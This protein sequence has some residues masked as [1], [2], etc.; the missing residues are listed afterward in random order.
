MPS[1]TFMKY[2]INQQSIPD[3]L[4]LSVGPLKLWQILAAIVLIAVA[5][6]I[7]WVGII[8]LRRVSKASD[9]TKDY[10]G[11][12]LRR[13]ELPISGLVLAG[14]LALGLPLLQLPSGIQ[15]TGTVITRA[16]AMLSFLWLGLRVVDA[17]GQVMAARAKATESKLDD[18]LVP[19][20]AKTSK[21]VLCV[22]GFVFVLQNLEVNVGSLIAGLGLGGL[23]FALAAKDTLANFFG[24]LM[25][26]VDKPFQIG[27]WVVINDVEGK[28]EEVGFR[29]SRLRTA[30]SSL[31]TVP[32]SLVTNAMI[33]NFGVRQYFTYETTLGLCYDTPAEKIE[34][35]CD[36]VREILLSD[37]RFSHRYFIVEFKEFSA[38]SLDIIISCH[39]MVSDRLL[40][41]QARTWLNLSILRFAE[42][43]GV[44]FAFPTQSLYLQG[45]APIGTFAPT[46][47]GPAEGFDDLNRN[48][49]PVKREFVCNRAK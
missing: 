42:Q 6:L 24:S 20:V 45:S 46:H 27:D 26:F 49:P 40:E 33:D 4:Q 1:L 3:W 5:R 17:V 29:T 12:I 16:V 43:L 47:F 10:S 44:S 19:L 34:A 21:V 15:S 7:S 2:S 37:K 8:A 41:K 31:V 22:I 32:N 28:I 13:S 23:A 38:S 18:Q 36:G 14:I 9:S 30:S 35:F 39:I 11:N 48:A 25:I